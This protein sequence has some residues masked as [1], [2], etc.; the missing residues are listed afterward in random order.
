MEEKKI[1]I[2]EQEVYFKVS[3]EGQPILILHGW[4]GSSD[5]WKKVQEMLSRDFKVFCP[6]L[7]GFGKSKTPCEVWGVSSYAQWVL[8]FM[9]SQKLKKVALL[10]HSFGGR[11]A[12]KFAYYYPEKVQSLIL[13]NSAGLKIKPSLKRRL[14][15]CFVG[16]FKLIFGITFI[17]KIKEEF[18]EM[19]YF[20]IAN[21]DYGKANA[22][23]K[24][25]MKKVIQE[26]LFRYL[27][28]IKARTLIIWG[29]KDK[30]VPL[31]H[32]K[33]F[34]EKIEGSQ[35]EILPKEAHSPH[36]KSPEKVTDLILSFLK[37]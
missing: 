24:E 27:S 13:C 36:L 9:E 5:S 31:S 19:F 35:L 1:I 2:Q 33:V 29:A 6:D 30:V 3:G 10:G 8:D 18:K 34:E 20:T 14:V 16:F 22:M 7:P 37:E 28:K 21:T 12:I 17:S 23:M 4:G 26:D 32:G 25:I 15:L 11:V